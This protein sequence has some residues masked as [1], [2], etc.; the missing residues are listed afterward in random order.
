MLNATLL[1]QTKLIMKLLFPFL[2]W[3]Y[4]NY[5]LKHYFSSKLW[6]VL[7]LFWFS[8][9]ILTDLTSFFFRANRSHDRTSKCKQTVFWGEKNPRLLDWSLSVFFVVWNVFDLIS[10]HRRFC[11]F[12]TIFVKS[13]LIF[14]NI[15]IFCHVTYLGVVKY[16]HE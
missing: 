12:Q 8:N 4:L 7:C 1:L 15:F 14:F 3:L 10:T 6:P 11:R 13:K 5:L 2:A 16:K 9:F